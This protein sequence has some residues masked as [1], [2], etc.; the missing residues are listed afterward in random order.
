MYRFSGES[1]ECYFSVQL[2]DNFP[3]VIASQRAS[4]AEVNGQQV[5][6]RT[7]QYKVVEFSSLPAIIFY[8]TVIYRY[9]LENSIENTSK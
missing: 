6:G 1:H 9:L 8:L 2:G 7:G 4:F 5:Q 3:D